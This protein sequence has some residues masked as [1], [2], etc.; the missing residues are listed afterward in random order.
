MSNDKTVTVH[1]PNDCAEK[2]TQ[3]EQREGRTLAGALL[4]LAMKRVQRKGSKVAKGK[5]DDEVKITLRMPRELH[6]SFCK[7]AESHERT[8]SAEV[9]RLIRERVSG[10]APEPDPFT[11]Q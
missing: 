8:F 1:L 9:R 2:L 10:A 4:W 6:E 7:V 3:I 5:D 11:G